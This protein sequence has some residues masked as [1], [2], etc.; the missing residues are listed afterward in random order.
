MAE[1]VRGLKARAAEKLTKLD[2]VDVKAY[3]DQLE[4]LQVVAEAQGPGTHERHLLFDNHPR[5]KRSV[6]AARLVDDD[7][8]AITLYEDPDW[9]LLTEVRFS[10]LRTPRDAPARLRSRRARTR[11]HGTSSTTSTIR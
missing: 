10:I 5:A 3:E 4:I 6:P 2:A 8:H 7:G 1:V 11:H 9:G